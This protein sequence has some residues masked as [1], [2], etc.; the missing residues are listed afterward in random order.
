MWTKFSYVCTRCDALIEVTANVEPAIDPACICD[1]WSFVTR[2]ALEP[3]VYSNVRNITYPQ[4]V[5]VNSN[6]YN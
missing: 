6:P 1:P 2:I 3:V 5:K 4:V